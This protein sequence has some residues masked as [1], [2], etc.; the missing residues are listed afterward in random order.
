MAESL[1]VRICRYIDIQHVDNFYDFKYFC[2]SF[3]P[4]WYSAIKLDED[5]YFHYI[6]RSILRRKGIIS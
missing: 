1:R 5:F 3:M 2:S 4:H 6:N